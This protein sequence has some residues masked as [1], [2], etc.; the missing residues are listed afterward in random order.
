MSGLINVSE[1]MTDPDFAQTLTLRR[2]EGSFN[3]YGEW[4]SSTPVDSSVTGAWQKVTERD[5]AQ[6]DLGEIKQ[7]V[8][9]FL[10]VTEIKVSEDDDKLSDR[11]IWAK[12][13][14]RYKVLKVTDNSDNGFY[15]AYASFEGTE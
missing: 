12:N 2:T 7:E 8:R 4:E 15:R 9:R 14:G 13:G 3:D 5:L 1:L 10:T 11:I 6:L